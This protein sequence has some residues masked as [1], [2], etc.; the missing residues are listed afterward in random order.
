MF[1]TSGFNLNFEQSIFH[2]PWNSSFGPLGAILDPGFG[3]GQYGFEISGGTL[4]NIGARFYSRNWSGGDVDV[5]Y[6]VDIQLTYPDNSTFN[7][8]DNITINSAYSVRNTAKI[9]TRFPSSG[10]IGLEMYFLMRFWLTPKFCFYSCITPGFDT[11]NL[12]KTLT[13][14][15]VSP[16]LVTYAC[17]PTFPSTSL[18]CTDPLLPFEMPDNDFGFE[19]SFDL[20]NVSTTSQILGNKCLKAVGEDAYAYVGVDVF[21]LIGGMK[22]PIISGVL[23]A[24]DDDACFLG[25]QICLSYTLLSATFGV[26]N[27][28]VQEFNFCPTV[29]SSVGFPS[30][31]EYTVTDPTNNNAIV[32]GPSQSDTI[33]FKVGNDVNIKYPCNYEFMETSSEYEIENTFSN[34]TYD[35]IRFD[36]TLEAMKVSFEIKG[37]ST[38]GLYIDLPCV[39]YYPSFSGWSIKWK[40]GWDPPGFW[41]PPAITLGPWGRELGPLYKKSFPL[42]ALP[43]IPWYDNSWELGGFNKENGTNHQ[44]KPKVFEINLLAKADVSCFGLQDGS[45]QVQLTNGVPPYTYYWSDGSSK[46]VPS[47]TDN[48]TSLN[49]GLHFVMVEDANGCQVIVDSEILQP[50]DSL[51]LLTNSINHVDCNSNSTGSISTTFTGGNNTYNY[52]WS[53]TQTNNSNASN[54]SAGIY[55]LSVTDEKGC[56]SSAEFTITQPTSLSLS[57]TTDSTTCF[58]INNG[59]ASSSVSGGTSPYTYNWSNGSIVDTAAGLAPGNHTLVVTDANNCIISSNFDIYEPNPI[60]I[61]QISQNVSCKGGN[62]GAIDLTVI[63]GTGSY[64]YVWYNDIPSALAAATQDISSLVSSNYSVFINDYN[65][66]QNTLTITINEPVDSLSSSI[67][68]SN[69]SC[70]NGSDGNI[71]LEVS[72]GTSP[73]FYNWS[74]SSS[75][76]DLQNLTIGNYIVTITDSKGCD[77]KDSSTLSEPSALAQSNITT[78]I[79]CHGDLTGAI[80]Y[81]LTGGTPPYNYSWSSSATTEDLMNIGAG[82]FTINS[83]DNNG[84]KITEKIELTQPSSPLSII[85]TTVPVSCQNGNNGEITSIVNG[86]TSPYLYN[87]SINNVSINNLTETITNQPSGTYN[88]VVS[89]NNNCIENNAFTIN[90]PD[91]PINVSISQTDILCNGDNTGAGSAI[92]SGGTSPYVY[93]WNNGSSSP[94]INSLNAGLYS[95]LVTDFNNCT[96]SDSIVINEPE[97]SISATLTI[98]DVSCKNGDDGFARIIPQGGTPSY[99]FSWSNGSNS[100]ESN[101]LNAGNYTVTVTDANNCIYSDIAIVNE[102]SN[103]IQID[104]IIIDSVKCKGFNDGAITIRASQGTTPYTVYLGDSTYNLYN[105]A[106]DYKLENIAAGLVHIN[107]TDANGCQV[108]STVSIPEPDT[109]NFNFSIVDADCYGSADGEVSLSVYGGTPD[110]KY[111]W[112]NGQ[113][114]ESISNLLANTYNVVISDANNCL[115]EGSVKVNQPENIETYIYISEVSCKDNDDGFIELTVKGGVPGYSYLWSNNNTSSAIYEL[116]PGKYIVEI[117]DNNGCTKIDTIHVNFINIEC[118]SPPTV[119]T[120]D[121]DGIND[122]WVLDKLDIYTNAIVQIY[123]NTGRLLYE[124]KGSYIPWN[125]MNNGNSLPSATYYYI[126]DLQNNS[127]AYTGTITILKSDK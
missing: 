40:C 67:I 110:Y 96:E 79:G 24:L 122:T 102:P 50:Q 119:F 78:N 42:G 8:G 7:R 121:G 72:G 9:E 36:F 66:C 74:N 115:V 108:D 84:C 90:E 31:V 19:G 11:G 5:N 65:E 21:D 94:T 20:P 68:A 75:S 56:S 26:S 105:S 76:E 2:V 10:N 113:T 46:T 17:P 47:N 53:P 52:D 38:P 57:I 126:I 48:N 63:G 22:I 117:T 92:V 34:N 45:M 41:A 123:N 127:P 49:A 80:D 29:Y 6:P 89:D 70:F 13:L 61:S 32:E 81:T 116:L 83:T 4:G 23:A 91:N 95:L 120:P 27:Y 100:Y 3:L 28:N 69:I 111:F 64:S 118:I 82:F 107:V 99:S 60:I 62:D 112:S 98:S 25:D 101:S 59:T 114:S 104:A 103:T 77:L 125:G 55:N 71:D 15:D 87:W 58:G 16:S 14:F 124:T 30:P 33:R 93:N 51:H 109:I 106:N 97:Y 12:S 86:G 73:Y 44:L 54:L 39:F 37:F 88:L 85:G 18:T 1:G 35:E 43:G